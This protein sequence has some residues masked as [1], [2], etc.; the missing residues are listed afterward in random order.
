MAERVTVAEVKGVTSSIAQTVTQNATEETSLKATEQV[1]ANMVVL[2]A[3]DIDALLQAMASIC[4]DKKLTPRLAQAVI[5]NSNQSIL[6][7]PTLP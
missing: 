7:N 6:S 2:D 4:A 5:R 3:K 1:A